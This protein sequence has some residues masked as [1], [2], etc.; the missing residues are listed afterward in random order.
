M[1]WYEDEVRALE[2]VQAADTPQPGAVLFY[3]SSSFRLWNTLA[4]DMRGWP[5]VNRAFGGSTLAACVHF[6]ERLVVPVAPRSMLV[7]AGDNDLGDGQAPAQ[8]VTSFEALL[9][10]VNQHLGPIPLGFVSIKPSP[11]RWNLREQIMAANEGARALLRERPLSY[12]I[13][14]YGPML[15]SDGRPRLELFAEDRLHLS[16]AGYRLW[17]HVL[18][19]YRGPLLDP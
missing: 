13:D 14:I 6:F 11:A 7:Y 5:V 9:A 12:F 8:V 10:K 17:A 2:R 1:Q 18:K 4:D 16:P 15:G 19:A 3:G